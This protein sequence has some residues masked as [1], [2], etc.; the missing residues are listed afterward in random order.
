MGISIEDGKGFLDIDVLIS[1]E[2][3]CMEDIAVPDISRWDPEV[4]VLLEESPY[5]LVYFIDAWQGLRDNILALME[6]HHPPYS[7]EAMLL[8]RRNALYTRGIGVAPQD[9][10][11]L[12]ADAVHMIKAKKVAA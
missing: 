12:R 11:A 3:Y 2:F 5:T 4:Q 6:Q 9:A 1:L 7:E 8:S 10:D